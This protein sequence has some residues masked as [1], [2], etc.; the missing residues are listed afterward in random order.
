MTM[1]KSLCILHLEDEPLDSTLMAAMLRGEG[2]DCGIARVDTRDAFVQ[3]PHETMVDAIVGEA[4]LALLEEWI[5][6]SGHE[7][8]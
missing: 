5:G 1:G 3:R 7:P 8:T 4:A 6:V 2:I